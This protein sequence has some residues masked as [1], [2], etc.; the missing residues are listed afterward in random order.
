MA[1]RTPTCTHHF[2]PSSLGSRPPADNATYEAGLLRFKPV[3]SGFSVAVKEVMEDEKQN[4]IIVWAEA[5][6]TWASAAVDSSFSKEEWGFTREY[7]FILSI[8]ESKEKIERV[9][10]FVDSKATEQLRVLMAR[11]LENVEKQQA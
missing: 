11:A 9:V 8:D 3:I 6:Q 5:G 10:E 2:H 1:L 4:R 7:M